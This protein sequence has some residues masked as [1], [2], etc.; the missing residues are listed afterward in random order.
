MEITCS[1]V[2]NTEADRPIV[3]ARSFVPIQLVRQQGAD[4]QE[5]QQRVAK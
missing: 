3:T 2:N 5:M 4:I 1:Q